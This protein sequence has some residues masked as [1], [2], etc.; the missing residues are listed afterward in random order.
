MITK[1]FLKISRCSS[2]FSIKLFKKSFW[3]EFQEYDFSDSIL[4]K[5]YLSKVSN[6]K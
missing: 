2:Y 3:G 5:I 6:I 1:L 4:N